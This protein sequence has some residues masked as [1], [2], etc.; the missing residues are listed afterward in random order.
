[1]TDAVLARRILSVLD[2]TD[3]S[4]QSSEER[5][6]ALCGAATRHGLVAAICIWPQMVSRAR[7]ALRDAPI[8]IAT[9]AN[10]PAGDG[11]VEDVTSDIAE[12]LADG[13]DEIDLVMPYQA[14]LRGEE[15]AARSM[16]E[17]VR[18]VVDRGRIL[19]V[20]LETG[21]FPDPTSIVAASRLAIEAGADFL[22]TST[23]AVETGA[24]PEAAEAV[25]GA[26][27]GSRRV[28]G[29]KASGGV[30]TLADARLY[31]ELAERTMGPGFITPATFRIGASGLHEAL[32]A[33]LEGPATRP[34][35]V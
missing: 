19:K 23:G 34:A 22:K 32:V 12:A 31:L 18:D 25:L 28:V 30:R 5:T 33:A 2:L 24:T 3:L 7:R 14:F 1:M 11:D 35:P 13:A 26:I 21:A 27:K 17:A 4:A 16:I 15:E 8:R 9:V 10:F 6:E 20:I 29:F